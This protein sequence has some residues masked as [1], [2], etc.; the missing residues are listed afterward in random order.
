MP[1]TRLDPRFSDPAASATSWA[2]TRRILAEAELFWLTTV[3]V[4]GRPH[5]SPLVAVW[6]DEA[7]HFCT[8]TGEQKF[9]NL[10]HNPWVTLTTGANTWDRG[11]DVVLE[12]EAE[13][14]TDQD[15]LTRLAAAWAAKW[16]GR[17]RFRPAEGGF[18]HEDGSPAA[19]F[20]VAPA[21]VLAFA[22]GT[23]AHTSHRF[24]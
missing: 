23:F 6:L 2:D 14:V 16:D 3:R 15:A 8:G 1:V 7:L 12:G 9:H 18:A 22:K 24:G 19:V 17:W 11:V 21:K 10:S 5:A 4:D 20:R 13:R